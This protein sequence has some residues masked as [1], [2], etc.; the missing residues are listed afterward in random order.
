MSTRFS[1]TISTQSILHFDAAQDGVL[2]RGV[3]YLSGEDGELIYDQV[4]G[5]R[6]DEVTCQLSTNTSSLIPAL[7]MLGIS[8]NSY[9]DQRPVVESQNDIRFYWNPSRLA[10]FYNRF[11]TDGTPDN[12]REEIIRRGVDF[13]LDTA[14][15]GDDFLPEEMLKEFYEPC[16][17]LGFYQ[18]LAIYDAHAGLPQLRSRLG[19]HVGVESILISTPMDR[20]ADDVAEVAHKIERISGVSSHPKKNRYRF[21]RDRRVLEVIGLAEGGVNM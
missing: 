17:L 13:L 2:V 11:G 12:E 7:R 21:P 18:G 15:S 6:A 1:I 4:E 5:L 14:D 8:Y 16:V 19:I 9:F 3:S 10:A 20:Y